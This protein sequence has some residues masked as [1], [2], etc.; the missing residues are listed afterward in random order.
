MLH[1]RDDELL[2]P[3][4]DDQHFYDYGVGGGAELLRVVHEGDH[5]GVGLG[6]DEIV[7]IEEY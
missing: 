6:N 5:P 4:E 3:M 1:L 7:D 2:Y